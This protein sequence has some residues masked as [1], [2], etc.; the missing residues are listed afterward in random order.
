MVAQGS[1]HWSVDLPGLTKD[2]A[3]ELLHFIAQLDELENASAER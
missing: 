2:G 3:E 1:N